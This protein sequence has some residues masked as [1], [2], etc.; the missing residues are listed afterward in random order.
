[1]AALTAVACTLTSN[2]EDEVTLEPT[3]DQEAE[4]GLI[5]KSDLSGTNPINFTWDARVYN[6]YQWL[7]PGGDIWNNISTFEFRVPLADGQ[8]QARAKLRYNAIDLGAVDA[9]GFGDIDLRFLTV[10]VMIPEKN[11]AIAL[12]SEFFIPTGSDS[13]IS[14]DAF[15]IG[16]QIFF[17]FFRV[18]NWID[19][20]APGYQHQFSVWEESGAPDRN[21]GIIDLFVLKTFNDRQQWVML[22]PQG[23]LDYESDRYW[24]Q[25][26]VEMGTMLPMKGHSVYVRPS[27]GIGSDSPYDWS[28]EAGYK[29][30]W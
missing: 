7:E 23:I 19:L 27:Y 5:S 2:A 26:D 3:R 25:F 6:E 11:F 22:N 8:W 1:M 20:V 13:L 10:P 9:S 28:L 17:G 21:L 15:S 30:V 29:I 12:G 14:T 16:P 18:F 24:T 4:A